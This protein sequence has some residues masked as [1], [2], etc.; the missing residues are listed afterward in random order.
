MQ[1][2]SRPCWLL[3]RRE[4]EAGRKVA[5]KELIQYKEGNSQ[6]DTT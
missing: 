4:H 6:G 1:H 2:G 3:D 5:T